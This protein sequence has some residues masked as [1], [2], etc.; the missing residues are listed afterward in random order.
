VLVEKLGRAVEALNC[1]KGASRLSCQGIQ[2]RPP[3][4]DAA[5]LA[6]II[7]AAEMDAAVIDDGTASKSCALM[8]SF[9]SHAFHHLCR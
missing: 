8:D 7:T 6:D 1:A 9:V 3:D 5:H 4:A 2:L